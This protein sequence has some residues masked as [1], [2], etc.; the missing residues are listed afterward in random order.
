M[1]CM[2]GGPW[3]A[4]VFIMA[5]DHRDQEMK[6]IDSIQHGGFRLLQEFQVMCRGGY[7]GGYTLRPSCHLL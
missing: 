7:Q 6:S 5:D 3:Q 4:L 2:S 1:I